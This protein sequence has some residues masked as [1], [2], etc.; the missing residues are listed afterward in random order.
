MWAS[1]VDDYGDDTGERYVRGPLETANRY[2]YR[3]VKTHLILQCDG[4][5]GINCM[6]SP[7]IPRKN[8]EPF[9]ILVKIDAVESLWG[10]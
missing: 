3:H 6:D 2:G 5:L 7:D 1:L 9:F 8:E 10:Q 4:E